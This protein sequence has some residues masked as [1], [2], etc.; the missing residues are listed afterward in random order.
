MR[1]LLILL[2]LTL[3]IAGVAWPWLTRLGLGHLPG[4]IRIVR[5]GFAFYF[6]LASGIL[7]SFVLSLLWTL[8]AWLWR[9]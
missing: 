1:A 9:R 3:L 7:V 5:P 6:P 4:D 2:G 8:L